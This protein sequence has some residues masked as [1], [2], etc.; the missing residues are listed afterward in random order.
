MSNSA[1]LPYRRSWPR[2]SDFDSQTK[3]TDTADIQLERD[4]K[5]LVYNYYNL[6]P[7]W[8]ADEEVQRVLL[9]EP[10]FF[11]TYPVSQKCID[12]IM[13]LAD[14]IAGIKI[15]VAEFECSHSNK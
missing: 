10:S 1:P 3:L 4:K 11:K 8:H 13:Q 14:N 5:T 6:D 15:L 2:F 7:D 9:L 12:F